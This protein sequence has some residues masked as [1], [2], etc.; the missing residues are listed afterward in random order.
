MR[1][2]DVRSQHWTSILPGA[3]APAAGHSAAREVP[4]S[5]AGQ[6]LDPSTRAF[7]EERFDHDFSGVRIHADERAA[8]LAEG[9][10]A[11]AYTVGSHV[12]FS[13]GRFAPGDAEGRE[14]LAHELAHVVQQSESRPD[15]HGARSSHVDT[16]EAQADHAA[17]AAVRGG[18]MPQMWPTA[19]GVQRRV[20]VRNVGRGE[21]SGFA[22]VGELLDRLDA[23]SQ[24]LDFALTEGN[25][26]YTLRPGGILSGFDRQMMSYIDGATDIRMRM[27]NRH[28]LMGDHVTGFDTQVEVDSWR[29]GYVDIDDL[30]A[31]S[32]LGL[33][34]VLVHVLEERSRTAN[35]TRRIGTESLNADDPARRP[36]F[37]R[38]HGQGILAE[39]E[40]L[41][42]FFGDPT[43]RL[44][45]AGTRRFRNARGDLIR[46]RQRVGGGAAQRGILAI[47]WEV[48][49]H[50]GN[51]V[52]TPEEYLE[53]MEAEHTREQVERERLQG[54]DQHR[55][56]GRGV[57]AP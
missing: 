20:S 53:F 36:E 39:M 17:S 21:Q 49:L 44:V 11:D 14:L 15:A 13:R 48:V 18:P 19:V 32:D 52:L 6:P 54:A 45:D 38:A 25:L 4:R 56:G 35:Y 57:P 34:T 31:S 29:A 2:S 41:R 22:R 24:G 12:T 43:I 51:R 26:T 30:L 3:N 42:G 55:A 40:V 27:T 10:G 47:S 46:E 23:I 50:D 5:H 37:L 16:L 33:Q 9:L 8:C 7:M 1:H 28:G